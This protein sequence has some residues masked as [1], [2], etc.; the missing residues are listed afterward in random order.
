MKERPDTMEQPILNANIVK[1]WLNFP[2]HRANDARN[3][4]MLNVMKNVK[5]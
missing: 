3:K 4:K 2:I 5:N 1:I